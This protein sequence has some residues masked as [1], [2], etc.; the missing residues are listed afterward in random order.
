[1]SSMVLNLVRSLIHIFQFES[2]PEPV[3][4]CIYFWSFM[5]FGS[6]SLGPT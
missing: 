2:R 1:M 4:F 3:S 6:C 5:M